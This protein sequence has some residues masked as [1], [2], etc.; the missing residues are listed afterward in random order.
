MFFSGFATR[1]LECLQGSLR[2][3]A[4]SLGPSVSALG[5]AARVQAHRDEGDDGSDGDG[6]DDDY[7]DGD[8]DGDG[9]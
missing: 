3:R 7:D 9:R 1:P 5:F 2:S 8:G 6:G 4:G